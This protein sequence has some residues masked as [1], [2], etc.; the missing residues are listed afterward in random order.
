MNKDTERQRTSIL[1]NIVH[2]QNKEEKSAKASAC[3]ATCSGC[4]GM[5]K[6]KFLLF[7][8]AGTNLCMLSNTTIM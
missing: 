4:I 7:S 2:Q 1:Q 6:A 3:V 8:L 5:R